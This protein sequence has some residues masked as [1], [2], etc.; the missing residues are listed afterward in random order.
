AGNTAT[1]PGHT[2]FGARAAW[3][4]MDNNEVWINI[5]N[6]TDERY[7]DRADYAFGVDRY[8]PGEPVNATVGVSR[9]F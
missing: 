7:A 3:E 4:W 1:Y 6:L 5:R 2:I 9:K 8:F